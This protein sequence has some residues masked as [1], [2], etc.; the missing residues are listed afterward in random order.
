LASNHPVDIDVCL[1]EKISKKQR[2]LAPLNIR[3]RSEIIARTRDRLELLEE[4][5]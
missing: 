3:N 4:M 1:A 2:R 5:M